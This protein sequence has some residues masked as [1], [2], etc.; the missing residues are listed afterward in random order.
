MAKALLKNPI[1]ALLVLVGIL[2]FWGW[3]APSNEGLRLSFPEGGLMRV[4]APPAWAFSTWFSLLLDLAS[5]VLFILFLLKIDYLENEWGWVGLQFF[6]VLFFVPEWRFGGIH[7]WALLGFLFAVWQIQG[8]AHE[9]K[10]LVK[11]Y[12]TGFLLG[13]LPLLTPSFVFLPVVILLLAAVIGTLRIRTL[14]L[15]FLGLISPIFLFVSIL[16]LIDGKA[17]NLHLLDDYRWFFPD[18]SFATADHFYG[19][20]FSMVLTFG[21]ALIPLERGKLVFQRRINQAFIFSALVLMGYGLL[22]GEG[23]LSFWMVVSPFVAVGSAR[24]ISSIRVWWL[25][26]SLLL[27]QWG[28]FFLMYL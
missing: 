16:F 17:V 4:W 19:L 10:L 14:F 15:F 24:A 21:V 28:L 23:A 2:V 6:T 1:L 12:D 22:V 5:G 26:D 7:H 9:K 20:A 25:Q 8:L 13:I 3:A 27:L 11:G 18:F